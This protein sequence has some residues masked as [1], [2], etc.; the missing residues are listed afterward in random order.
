MN[1]PSTVSLKLHPLSLRLFLSIFPRICRFFVIVCFI[2][3]FS[4]FTHAFEPYTYARNGQL[5]DLKLWV[6]LRGDELDTT[7]ARW[8][9]AARLAANEGHAEML[10]YLS[11]LGAPL[12]TFD[13]FGISP[14]HEAASGNHVEIIRWLLQNGLPIDHRQTVNAQTALQTAVQRGNLEATRTLLA[15]DADP[16]TPSRKGSA[17][18]L[19]NDIEVLNI[20]LEHWA[21]HG[22][23]MPPPGVSAAFW[24]SYIGQ[25][26][27]V[28]V[29]VLQADLGQPNCNALHG[30]IL[31]LS[32]IHI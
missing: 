15:L 8:G 23:G 9:S 18:E 14:L 29:S 6:K 3:G 16:I 4:T 30:A 20:L 11:T 19:A 32:L 7:T 5:A 28:P 22:D 26:N 17:F 12:D 24:W 27:R 25:L 2:G 1:T 31:S 13:D 10:E 21:K